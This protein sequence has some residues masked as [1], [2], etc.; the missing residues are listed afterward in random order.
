M[1][2]TARGLMANLTLISI[3]IGAG[4]EIEPPRSEPNHNSVPHASNTNSERAANT[5]PAPAANSN[6][7][8]TESPAG[9]VS[10]ITESDLT[11]TLPA[12][13]RLLADDKFVAD[14]L[15]TRLNLSDTDL[16]QI[17][18]IAREGALKIRSV[19]AED[20]HK[21]NQAQVR[22]M[23]EKAEAAITNVIG[24]ERRNQL[25]AM[26]AERTRGEVSDTLFSCS[27]PPDT[28][29]VVNEP[30]FRMDVFENGQLVKSYSVGIGYP[31]YPLPLGLREVDT[32]IF[33]PSWT[34][35]DSSWVEAYGKKVKVGETVNPGD[36]RNPLGVM[37]IPLGTAA[38]IHGGKRPAQ[39]GGFASHGCVGL[40]N[41]QARDF[42][43]LVARLGGVDLDDN[44]IAKYEKARTKTETIKL[45][46]KIP[47][48]LR[49][50]TITV[51]HGLL[52]IYRDVY[53]RYTNTEQNVITVL[54]SCGA[55][56]E[57][58]P[59]DQRAAVRKALVDMSRDPQGRIISPENA[60]GPV[61][62][63]TKPLKGRV[64]RKV[65]VERVTR[66]LK[67][68]KEVVIEVASLKGKGYPAAADIDT[69]RNLPAKK[70]SSTR[71]KN[72][73]R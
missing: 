48:E 16:D 11:V 62:D 17:R 10:R 9:V 64:N 57:Q 23:A 41:A 52:H 18:V 70:S 72:S 44:Q 2:K 55:P 67:G 38:L 63:E 24:P 6:S 12:L 8:I 35:P 54:S 46:R 29:I 7:G 28:R 69:G 59:E 51:E 4:C 60:S 66:T 56:F 15:K 37:K 34:P 3:L 27:A 45:N 50:D 1:L 47:V 49:Y 58:L 14:Q 33:N 71:R 68:Q 32:I 42:A 26:V 61:A 40:T 21:S 36:S 20:E 5:D 30:A 73:R 43:M 22:K 31:E 13:N 19:S 39:V 25:F 65:Q 53:A